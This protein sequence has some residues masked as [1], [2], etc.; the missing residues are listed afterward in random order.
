MGNV[1]RNMDTLSNYRNLSIVVNIRKF[2][3]NG[4]GKKTKILFLIDFR[5][6]TS[7]DNMDVAIE[8]EPEI[9]PKISEILAEVVTSEVD[10]VGQ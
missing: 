1:H 8:S 3:Y 7:M 6:E 9:Y 2:Y 4:F 5:G 10:G